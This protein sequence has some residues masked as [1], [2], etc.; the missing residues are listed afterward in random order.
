MTDFGRP[1]QGTIEDNVP[2]EPR[3]VNSNTNTLNVPSNNSAYGG[4]E[5]TSSTTASST[6]K[7]LQSP[8]PK[9][10]HKMPL[11]K[12]KPNERVAGK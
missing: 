4:S 9:P 2:G 7:Y 5:L 3:P 10:Q 1:D 12:R 8:N 6:S 11:S